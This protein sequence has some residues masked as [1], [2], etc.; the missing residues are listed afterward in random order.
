MVVVVVVVLVGALV[1]FGVSVL[2]FVAIEQTICS[3]YYIIVERGDRPLVL[4]S[5]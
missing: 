4:S 3:I 1:T 5:R 2:V